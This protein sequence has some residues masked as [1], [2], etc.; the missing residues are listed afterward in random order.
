MRPREVLMC[1]ERYAADIPV[2][3]PNIQLPPTRSDFSKQVASMPR[4]CSALTVGDARRPGP[5]DRG[6]RSLP[7]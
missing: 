1:R 4:W 5:D 3:L 7:M 2:V 6:A